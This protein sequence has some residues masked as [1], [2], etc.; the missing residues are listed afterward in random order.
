M[1]LYEIE[2]NQKILDY[3]QYTYGISNYQR[4][5]KKVFYSIIKKRPKDLLNET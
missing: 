2:P 5:F 3:V 1:N 4:H